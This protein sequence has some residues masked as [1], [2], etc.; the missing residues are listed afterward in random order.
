MEKVGKKPFLLIPLFAEGSHSLIKC[1]EDAIFNGSPSISQE[2]MEGQ[3]CKIHIK[4]KT[5]KVIV[6]PVLVYIFGAPA[7]TKNESKQW[8]RYI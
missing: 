4:L 3:E 8:V 2:N 6:E 7:L 1:R 5:Y